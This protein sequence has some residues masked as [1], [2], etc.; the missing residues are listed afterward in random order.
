MYG[1]EL[2]MDLYGINPDKVNREDIAQWLKQLCELVKM[3]R[4][5]LYFWDY[6]GFPEEKATAPPHLKGVSGVQFITTSNVTF[7]ALDA[8]ECYINVFTC[9]E[10]SVE[11][12]VK[13]TADWFEAKDYDMHVL[14]RGKRTKL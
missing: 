12:A 9:K 1:K 14:Q 2:I 3:N 8:G 11:D 4:E 7:H 6:E 5:P 13:F 10:F